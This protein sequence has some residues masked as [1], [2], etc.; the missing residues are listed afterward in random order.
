MESAHTFPASFAQELLWLIHRTSPESTAYNVPRLRRLRGALD[1]DALNRSLDTLVA[2]HEILRTTYQSEADHVTQT[3]HAPRAVPIE[4]VDVS[5]HPAADRE[6]AAERIARQ[7]MERPF[8][9]SRDSVLRATLVR[10]APA[11]HV[12]LLES[13]HIAFD[14]WSRNIL[15]RELDVAYRAFSSGAAPSLPDLPI[16]YADFSI[17]QR[18]QLAGQRLEG[19]LAYW[20]SALAGASL[21]LELPHDRGRTERPGFDGTTAQLQLEPA[22]VDAL[23]ALARSHGA[24]LYMVLLAGYMTVLA[25]YSAQDDVLVGSPVLGRPRPETEPLIGYFANTVVQRGHFADDPSFATLLGRVRESTL[26]AYDH[27]DVPF[28]RLVLELEGHRDASRS[29]IFQ[30]VFT[31]LMGAEESSPILGDVSMEPFAFDATTTKFDLTLL[32]SPRPTGVGLIF[33]YRTDLFSAAFGDR[34]LGHLRELLTNAVADPSVPVSRLSLL[35]AGERSALAGFNATAVDEGAQ[36]TLVQLFEAQAARVPDRLAVVGPRASATAAG[37]VAGTLA[38]NYVE[39]DTR[40][41]QLAHHLR[42]LG[43]AA[44]VPVGLLLDRETDALVGLMGILKSGAAYMP[45]AVDAPAARLAQQLGESGARIVVTNATGA[46]KLPSSVVTVALDRHADLL[47]QSP[48]TSPAPVATPADL[49]YVL[50]TSG[51][52][53][54]PKG[55]AVTHANAVHY[56]RAVSRVLSDAGTAIEGDGFA[57]LDGWRFGMASTLAADL[58][59]TSLL[60][61]LLSGG[62]LHT[63]SND[64]TTDP[65]RFAEYVGVHQFDVLKITPNHIAA[66][67]AGKTG[68]ALAQLLPKRWL[69]LGGEALRL[70][71]ARGVFAAGAC[72]VL[73][74]Y[75]PTETTVGVLTHEVTTD[76][77]AAAEREG[78]VTIPI[79][80]PLA[81]TSAFIVSAGGQEQPVGIPG[82]LW[83]GGAGVTN[84]YLNRNDLTGERFVGFAGTRVYRTGDRVRRLATGAIE[85]L[86]RADD[87]VKI[88][89]FRIELGEIEHVLRRH[90]GVAQGVVVRTDVDGD[91]RLVAYAVAKGAGYAVSH[92]DRPTSEKLSEWIAAQLPDYMVPSAVLLIDAIPLTPNGKVDTARLPAADGAQNTVDRYVAPA[93]PTET[94]LASIW[95]EVLKKERVGRTDNFLDLGGHSLLAIRVLGKISK[96]FGVRLPLRTLFDAPTVEQLGQRVDAEVRLAALESMSDEEAER[97]LGTTSRDSAS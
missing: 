46:T 21:T 72:R 31:Q 26:G 78:A 35:T 15:F 25:R 38:L 94:Q 63:L 96:S 10:L 60:P 42:S 32:F 37:S 65:A 64:V 1:V 56:A 74:H 92:S 36:A 90:P 33:R 93:T 71:V 3:I 83:I 84:G 95:M 28:E 80:A 14:G 47:G 50:F 70:D 57:A 20:R 6:A 53:G 41:N 51:S 5:Q 58:G 77:I 66:L 73:N 76:S 82:E 81:N 13:H 40:A 2:R 22:L 52:T 48:N 86:G 55:V 79:G 88:R 9:L 49:A 89:G 43:A 30:V 69:V 18:E 23:T 29:P 54:V 87:Q 17:W 97:L 59:N 85:F 62:T 45:L 68:A 16:Q 8:D 67:T 12:L 91:A 75:G 27:Q 24:T 4:I 61:S 19:L 44:N 39:L 11:D 34:F 7:R